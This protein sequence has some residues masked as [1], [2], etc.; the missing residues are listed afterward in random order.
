MKKNEGYK[1]LKLEEYQSIFVMRGM[2]LS[3]RDISRRLGRS[4]SSVHKVAT[5]HR[6]PNWKTWSN[7]SALERAEYVCGKRSKGKRAPRGLKLE[8]DKKLLE[9][10]LDSLISKNQSPEQIASQVPC[11]FGDKTLSPKS[12]YRY[13][14]RY[15]AGLLKYLSERGKPR[16]QRVTHRRGRFKQASPDKRPISQRPTE[17]NERLELGHWEGDTLVSSRAGSQ[18]VLSL[19]E[20]V[21]RRQVFFLIPDLKAATVKSYLTKFLESLPAQARKTLTL[22]RGSE[23]APSELYKLEQEFSQFKIYF[24]DAYKPSQKGSVENG[25]RGFRW[26]FPK[27]TNFDDCSQS[28]ITA[29]ETILN[30]KPMKLHSFKSPAQIWD[31]SLRLFS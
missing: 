16:R 6:H 20:R 17:A 22:D 9:F 3:Y 8:R 15:P 4:I 24:C 1:H 12:I 7:L 13:I 11:Y 30:N 27:G 29:V 2:G 25:H 5:K 21:T 10:T 28:D 18:A 31:S 23:F 19:R 14:K 26:H